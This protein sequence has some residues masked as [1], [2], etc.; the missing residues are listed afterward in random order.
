MMKKIGIGVILTLLLAASI[1]GT[2]FAQAGSPAD[3]PGTPWHLDR[4]AELL[5][6]TVEKIQEALD[7]GQTLQELAEA[8]GIELPGR[9][10][11]FGRRNDGRIAELL[12]MTPE[13]LKEALDSGQT[14]QE[15]AEAAGIELP[16]RPAGFGMR[17]DGRMAELLGM[18]PE[19]LKEA[20][21]SGQTLQELAEAAGVELPGRPAGFGARGKAPFQP[22]TT[23]E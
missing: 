6:M 4:L 12:G 3:P 21:D 10:A 16:E 22:R 17:G 8:A 11:G 23:E 7:S 1:A 18:T 20:L 19:E 14:L 9:P 5:D 13:E 15:L 2:A